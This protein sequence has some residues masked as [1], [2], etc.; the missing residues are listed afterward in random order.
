MHELKGKR[1]LIFQQRG[2]AKRVGHCLALKLQQEGCQLAA[3][4]LKKLA[5]KIITE[6][7]TVNYEYIVN[8]DEIFEY[9]EKFWEM[10]IFR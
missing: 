1:I 6:Q 4:T 2:W 7:K 10:K 8:I 3:L 5:H 9:P